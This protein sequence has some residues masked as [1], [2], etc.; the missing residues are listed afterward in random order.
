MKTLSVLLIALLAAASAQPSGFGLGIIAGEPTGLSAKA[1][2]GG[3]VAVD[4]AAAWSVYHYEALHVHADLLHH[5]FDLIRV[6]SGDLPV[7]YGI[8]GR[9]KL[10]NAGRGEADLRLGVRVPVGLSYIF[11]AAPVDVFLEVAPLL[12]LIP[13][14]EFG[15]NAAVGARYYFR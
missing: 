1:W 9:L 13:K 3:T 7:Y 8:G 11:E 5:N 14:T 4:A 15:V 10:A 2:L 12:D 6:E